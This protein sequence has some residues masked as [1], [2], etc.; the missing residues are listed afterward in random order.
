MFKLGTACE[1][2]N[3]SPHLPRILRELA[4]V[5]AGDSDWETPAGLDFLD[6]MREGGSS[7]VHSS[8]ALESYS[9]VAR[10]FE[11]L[12]QEGRSSSHWYRQ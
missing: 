6:R 2:A 11:Q 8:D 3:T 7:F 10:R 5:A 4:V 1:A 12:E 9:Q